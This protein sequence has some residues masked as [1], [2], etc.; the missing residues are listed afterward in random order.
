MRIILI[1]LLLTGCITPYYQLSPEERRE[2]DRQMQGWNEAAQQMK[3]DQRYKEEQAQKE[4]QKTY[5]RTHKKKSKT[6]CK[7]NMFNEVVCTTEED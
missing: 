5:E 1:S 2:R 7:K 6:I 3:E 4:E